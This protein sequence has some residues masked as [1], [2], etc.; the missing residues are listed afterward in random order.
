MAYYTETQ[1]LFWR[2]LFSC[3]YNVCFF[4]KGT[5]SYSFEM[6]CKVIMINSHKS[7]YYI[8][9]GLSEFEI[10]IMLSLVGRLLFHVDTGLSLRYKNGQSLPLHSTWGV[11]TGLYISA[12]LTDVRGHKSETR[13]TNRDKMNLVSSN[14]KH[15]SRWGTKPQKQFTS[16]TKEHPR[17]PK[18]IPKHCP[19]DSWQGKGQT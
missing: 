1:I 5:H 12:W 2:I 11:F 10:I 19:P 3:N 17:M 14:I 13:D 7:I 4:F 9:K 15:I 6:Y 8:L 18:N 16:H